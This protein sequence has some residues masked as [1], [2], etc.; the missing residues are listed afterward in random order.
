M[1]RDSA[2]VVIFIVFFLGKNFEFF[3]LC[4]FGAKYIAVKKVYGKK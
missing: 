2:L 4:T 3:Y 1:R